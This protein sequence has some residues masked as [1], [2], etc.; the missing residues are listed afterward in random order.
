MRPFVAK[1]QDLPKGIPDLFYPKT[2]WG[3]SILRA[4]WRALSAKPFRSFGASFSRVAQAD[5]DL[6]VMRFPHKNG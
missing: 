3:V 2:R 4:V 6:P 5:R 1:V